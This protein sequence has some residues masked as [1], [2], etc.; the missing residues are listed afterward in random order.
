[1]PSP[2]P[3]YLALPV[4][5]LRHAKALLQCPF[6]C[7]IGYSFEMMRDERVAVYYL[8]AAV[9]L[10][11]APLYLIS[12][13]EAREL[14][15]TGLGWF[16]NH[17]RAMRLAARA[18]V[19]ADPESAILPT[20]AESPRAISAGEMCANVGIVDHRVRNRRETIRRARAKVRL[21]PVI[22]DALSSPRIAPQ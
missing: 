3:P 21:Y 9:D 20:W 2:A 14:K 15:R 12:R 22:F 4:P 11:D 7:I 6:W 13:A 19:A 10:G 5:T 18:P 16:I 17:G 1:M 8:N